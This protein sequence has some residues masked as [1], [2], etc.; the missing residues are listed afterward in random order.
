M[1]CTSYVGDTDKSPRLAVH[2]QLSRENYGIQAAVAHCV[3]TRGMHKHVHVQKPT[4]LTMVLYF[5]FSLVPLLTNKNRFD[6][7]LYCCTYKVA[8]ARSAR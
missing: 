4:L 3:S 7:L 5:V 1:N 6:N 8:R 2:V